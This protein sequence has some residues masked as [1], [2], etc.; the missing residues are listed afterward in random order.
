MLMCYH[1]F[2][3]IIASRQLK[4]WR[5]SLQG[6]NP[7]EYNITTYLSGWLSVVC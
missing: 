5:K 6:L 4:C 3:V 1:L 2:Q 7:Q